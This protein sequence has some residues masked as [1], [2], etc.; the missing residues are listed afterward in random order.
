MKKKV[1]NHFIYSV[2]FLAG[3]IV[4]FSLIYVTAQGSAPN[5]GHDVSRIWGIPTCTSGQYLTK[6]SAGWSCVADGPG[7]GGTTPPPPTP[8]GSGTCTSL[9]SAPLNV[10]TSGS[11]NAIIDL[12]LNCIDKT[13]LFKIERTYQYNGATNPTPDDLRKAIFIE[14]SQSSSLNN[15]GANPWSTIGGPNAGN[16]GFNGNSVQSI[17]ASVD[18]SNLKDDGIGDSVPNK[19]F[20]EATTTGS[21]GLY[22]PDKYDIFHCI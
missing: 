5:P 18:A 7:T 2:I 3:I 6:T 14:F 22:S 12:P 9:L 20:F 1:S 17:I 19:L 21:G 13:C 16:F 4:A 10:A 15:A 11:A 8:G